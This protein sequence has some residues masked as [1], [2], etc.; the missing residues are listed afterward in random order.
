MNPTLRLPQERLLALDPADV[1]AYVHARGWEADQQVSSPEA[2][3]YHLPADPQ[4]EILLP[5]DR[6]FADYALRLGEVLQALAT[7]ERRTAWEVLEDLLTRRTA[8]PGNGPAPGKRGT[9]GRTSAGKAK[10]DAS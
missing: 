3:V 7:A 6:D 5:R 8:A 10:R 4:A 9:S 1:E 2:G